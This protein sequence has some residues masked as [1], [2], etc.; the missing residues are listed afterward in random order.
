MTYS[1]SLTQPGCKETVTWIIYNKPLYIS[2][3][4]VKDY[5]PFQVFAKIFFFISASSNFTNRKNKFCHYILHLLFSDIV[6]A[7]ICQNMS[8]SDRIPDNGTIILGHFSQFLF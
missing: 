6:S 2:G 7:H 3:N 1:G 4:Q 8:Y 5:L